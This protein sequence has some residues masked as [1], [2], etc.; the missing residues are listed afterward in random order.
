[1]K[2]GAPLTV[3][4][5]TSALAVS[6]CCS[7]WAVV[8]SNSASFS[9]SASA[10]SSSLSVVEARSASRPDLAASVAARSW[11]NGVGE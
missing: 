11:N 8:P 6:N 4:D 10:V 2:G 1:M 7:S 5:L 3:D 9:A